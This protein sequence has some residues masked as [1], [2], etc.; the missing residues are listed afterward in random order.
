MMTRDSV[1]SHR[2]PLLAPA[3]GVLVGLLLSGAATLSPSDAL[4]Q[5]DS[6][7]PAHVRFREA[8]VPSQPHENHVGL[9]YFGKGAVG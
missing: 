9:G 2:P 3:V 5:S 1:R 7:E 4:A 8:N 6:A